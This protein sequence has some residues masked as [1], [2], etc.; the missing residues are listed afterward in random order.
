MRAPVFMSCLMV[1]ATAAIPASAA[2]TPTQSRLK[3]QLAQARLEAAGLSQQSAKMAL[4]NDTTLHQQ[5]VSETDEMAPATANET[6]AVTP[7]AMAAP[8][9]A[10]TSSVLPTTMQSPMAQPTTLT[11]QVTSAPV[12]PPVP[13]PV[14]AKPHAVSAAPVAPA[15]QHAEA[16][17]EL[18]S[19][20]VP[21]LTPVVPV[22]TPAPQPKFAP[23]AAKRVNPW[24]IRT[25]TPGKTATSQQHNENAFCLLEASFDNKTTLMIGQRADGYSTLGINYGIDMLQLQHPYRATVT[26][27]TQFGEDFTA[28]AQSSQLLITQMGRKPSF[29]SALQT[30]R[31]LTLTL[32]GV[33]SV[34]ALDGFQ[35]ILPQFA[36]CLTEIGAAPETIHPPAPIRSNDETV[37]QQNVAPV[38][39]PMPAVNNIPAGIAV[40]PTGNDLSPALLQ[41]AGIAADSFKVNGTRAIWHDVTHNVTG[42]AAIAQQADAIDAANDALVQAEIACNGAFESQMG[43]PETV[44]NTMS[45][46]SESK[47]TANGVTHVSAWLTIQEASGTQVWELEAPLAKKNGAF[48]LRDK[49]VTAIQGK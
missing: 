43:L 23:P 41:R 13:S 12:M 29:F 17:P 36:D 34:F 39:V 2:S 1:L 4:E 42:R 27:D 3:S 49:M 5:A 15:P 28:A 40:P 35:S 21:A 18:V 32:P 8:P 9:S 11:P 48:A 6:P 46:L 38:I 22:N 24:S 16:L 26:I 31:R 20:V 7:V 14:T 44:G 33:T 25:V 47:C 19:A 45:Q 30:G 37:A 10:A